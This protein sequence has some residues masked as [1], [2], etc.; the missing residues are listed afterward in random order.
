MYFHK[1][2]KLKS[3]EIIE[4]VKKISLVLSQ[5]N[6]KYYVKDTFFNLQIEDY[7]QCFRR[8]YLLIQIH[9]FPE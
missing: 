9:H 3:L 1:K 7:Y 2:K 4:I 8:Q 5:K 6:T